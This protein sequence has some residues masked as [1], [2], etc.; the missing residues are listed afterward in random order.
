MFT[1]RAWVVKKEHAAEADSSAALPRFS[2]VSTGLESGRFRYLRSG[3]MTATLAAS[4]FAMGL[5][6]QLVRVLR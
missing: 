6:V 2:S 1:A 3:A 4:I 5:A